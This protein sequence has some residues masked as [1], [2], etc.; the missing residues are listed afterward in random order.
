MDSPLY[1]VQCTFNDNIY[2]GNMSPQTVLERL[3]EKKEVDLSWPPFQFHFNDF[4]FCQMRETA[5]RQQLLH[6]HIAKLA[7]LVLLLLAL[8]VNFPT[9]ITND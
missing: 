2:N 1:V 6:L 3:G 4:Y 5:L 9:K 7:A 8:C